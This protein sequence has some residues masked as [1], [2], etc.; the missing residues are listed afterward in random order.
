[1][2]ALQRYFEDDYF[3]PI[4]VKKELTKEYVEKTS[5]LLVVPDMH[6]HGPLW[7]IKEGTQATPIIRDDDTVSYPWHAWL[8]SDFGDY[9]LPIEPPLQE[10]VQSFDVWMAYVFSVGHLSLLGVLIMFGSFR[11]RFE[12][13]SS[14]FQ[15]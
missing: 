14:A 15:Y 9:D 6:E 12:F 5:T 13:P 4:D 3:E 2:I 8:A 1:M 11:C 7:R 10:D